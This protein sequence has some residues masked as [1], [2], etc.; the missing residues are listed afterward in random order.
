MATATASAE[1]RHCTF[2]IVGY[3][4][5]LH[6]DD[7]IG[8]HVVTAIATWGVPNLRSLAV[9]QLTPELSGT[10]AN[11]EYVIFVDACRM[12]CPEGIRFRPIN[13]CGSEPGGCSIPALGHTCDPCSILALTQSAYGRRPQAWWLEVPAEDFGVGK[14]LSAIADLGIARALEK[15]QFLLRHYSRPKLPNQLVCL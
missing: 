3:G 13:A 5:E 4:N 10:L 15:I 14:G 1:T 11:A 12:N 8:S 2:L 9:R 7:A 6:G